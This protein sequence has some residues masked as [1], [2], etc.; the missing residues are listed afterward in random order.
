M[1]KQNF[2]GRLVADPQLKNV[3]E[4]QV[5]SFRMAVNGRTKNDPAVFIDCEAWGKPAEVIAR[6]CPKGKKLE[7]ATRLRQHTYEKDG[8][9]RTSNIYVVE[10]FDL[11]EKKSE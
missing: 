3:G 7:V 4:K 8:Q 2:S 1:N 11:P 5:C 6:Y 10:D 9:K